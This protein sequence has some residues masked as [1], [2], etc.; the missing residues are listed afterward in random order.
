MRDQAHSW[1]RRT[2]GVIGTAVVLSLV[3]ASAAEAYTE[4]YCGQVPTN[5]QCSTAAGHVFVYN[6]AQFGQAVAAPYICQTMTN[7]GNQR[8]G[9]SCVQNGFQVSYWYGAN[10]YWKANCYFIDS[11]SPRTLNCTAYT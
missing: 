9:G 11:R 7:S 10:G 2:I 4:Y 8:P 5:Y 6:G 3:G 1:V